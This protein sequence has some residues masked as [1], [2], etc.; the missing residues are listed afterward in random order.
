MPT[1]SFEVST[2]T[3]L[4]TVR[5]DVKFLTLSKKKGLLKVAENTFAVLSFRVGRL[6]VVSAVRRLSPP[7][8]SLLSTLLTVSRG[9]LFPHL[10]FLLF[11]FRRTAKPFP[12]LLSGLFSTKGLF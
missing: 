2:D 4:P 9:A 8:Q 12:L 11:R 3:V 5:L 6:T 10:T 7:M 1:A